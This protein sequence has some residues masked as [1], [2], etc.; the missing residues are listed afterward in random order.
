MK[1]EVAKHETLFELEQRTGFPIR[2]LWVM[3]PGQCD[4][5]GRFKW[6]PR[7]MKSDLLPFDAL[8]FEAVLD[9]LLEA[10]Q[11][12]KYRV[13]SE[14]FGCV[15]TFGKHQQIGPREK[16]SELPATDHADEII[17]RRPM[18][19]ID[20]LEGKGKEGNGSQERKGTDQSSTL[21]AEPSVAF[22]EF[23]VVGGGQTWG[24]TESM[25]SE[26][27]ELFPAV[28][29]RREMRAALAW[30]R[31]NPGRKKTA[32]GMRRFLTT[33]LTRTNDRGG[34]GRMTTPT[35]ARQIAPWECPHVDRCNNR[36]Q[37]QNA[38]I[39]GRPVRKVAS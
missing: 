36:E 14:W 31:A 38:T 35:A 15:P 20:L 28:D 6:R 16:A 29:V 23:P 11:I 34:A 32:A 4:R 19:G 10:G 17:D 37:C 9:V 21:R 24:L 7:P 33:W 30:V 3:L 18:S 8:E 5:E 13:G 26:F 12:V 2:F 1:P 27:D 39:L 25:V 22:L